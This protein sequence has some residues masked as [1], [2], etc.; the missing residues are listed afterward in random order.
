MV[1]GHGLPRYSKSAFT[2]VQIMQTRL[3]LYQRVTPLAKLGIFERNFQTGEI[4]WNRIVRSILE[5]NNEYQPSLDDAINLYKHPNRL[6]N[7][8]VQQ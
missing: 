8:L 7:L 1:Q 2:A 4:Y 6:R 3:D 5:V